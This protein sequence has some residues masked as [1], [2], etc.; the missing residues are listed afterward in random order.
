MS[1][2]QGKFDFSVYHP[3]KGLK[4]TK[5]AHTIKHTTFSRVR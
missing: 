4:Y 2:S 3:L 1:K 5:G